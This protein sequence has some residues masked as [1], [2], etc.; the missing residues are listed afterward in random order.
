MHEQTSMEQTCH[1]GYNPG[2]H[3]RGG[4]QR[5]ANESELDKRGGVSY[6][7]KHAESNRTYEDE[8]TQEHRA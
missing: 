2:N 8:H 1:T 4:K 6:H 5:R 3:R 7:V